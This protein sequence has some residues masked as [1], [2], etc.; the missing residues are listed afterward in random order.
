MK[1][2]GAFSVKIDDTKLKEMFEVD[3]KL[4]IFGMNTISR[5]QL[6]EEIDPKK[7]NPALPHNCIKMYNVG[8]SDLF[9]SGIFIQF[10]KML[11]QSVFKKHLNKKQIIHLMFE[12]MKHLIACERTYNELVDKINA[13]IDN[14]DQSAYLKSTVVTNLPF[15]EGLEE[16]V[17]IF[18]ISQAGH[19]YRDTIAL[20]KEFFSD[21]MSNKQKR[22][23]G[24][25]KL[26]KLIDWSSSKFGDIDKFTEYLHQ[27]HN[28]W[29]KK[30]VVMRNKLEHPDSN[31]FVEILNFRM[32]PTQ[33]VS[34][35][36]IKLHHKDFTCENNE[37]LVLLLH[38]YIQNL[39]IFYENVLLFCIK[40][41]IGVEDFSQFYEIYRIQD[42]KIDIECP[43]RY[44]L[45]FDS[46]MFFTQV[47]KNQEKN[48]AGK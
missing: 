8:T 24:D 2:E 22:E 38:S 41:N 7:T 21:K 30:F 5:M 27:E 44:V 17:K 46:A 47:K 18:F 42:D 36:S 26:N 23:I 28:N 12:C 40:K 4:I 13:A 10:A 16:T 19:F 37:N 39:Y 29:V 6:A 20:I 1:R 45:E 15:I 9:V 3:E 25:K 14:F 35:P 34:P 31:E 32:L 43:I 33:E 11:K 48:K